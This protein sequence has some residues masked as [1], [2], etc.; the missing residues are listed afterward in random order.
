MITLLFKLYFRKST[1]AAPLNINFW[2]LRGHFCKKNTKENWRYINKKPTGNA[3]KQHGQTLKHRE[4]GVERERERERGWRES[5][6]ERVGGKREREGVR[7]RER[8]RE[9]ERGWKERE[10]TVT[11]RD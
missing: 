2:R 4:R 6:G 7:E 5:E 1:D 9:R 11:V 8:E 3:Q 10:R